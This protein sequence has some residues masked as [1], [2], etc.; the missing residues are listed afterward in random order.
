MG[1]RIGYG[2]HSAAKQGGDLP[3]VYFVVFHLSAVYR[4]HVQRVAQNELDADSA[5]QVCHPVP[6]EDALHRQDQVLLVG[7]E[8]IGEGFRRSRQVPVCENRSFVVHDADVHCPCVRLDPAVKSMV[9]GV[10]SHKASSLG[11]RFLDESIIPCFQEGAL[12]SI[13]A[14]QLTA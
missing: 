11:Y 8:R 7:P 3:G 9:F 12:M 14:L 10:E 13:M 2:E 6:G 1:I 4:L 5:A